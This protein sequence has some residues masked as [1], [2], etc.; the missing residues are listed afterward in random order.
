M[1]YLLIRFVCLVCLAV[2]YDSEGLHL[3]SVVR[4]KEKELN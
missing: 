2:S 4:R 1:Q 3:V